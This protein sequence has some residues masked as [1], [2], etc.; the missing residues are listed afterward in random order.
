MLPNPAF[1]FLYFRHSRPSFRLG[2]FERRCLCLDCSR[3]TAFSLR[4]VRHV[5]LC[6]FVVLRPPACLCLLRQLTLSDRGLYQYIKY[7]PAFESGIRCLN[8][9][10]DQC[11]VRQ[12][13]PAPAACSAHSMLLAAR[14]RRLAHESPPPLGGLYAAVKFDS[15]RQQILSAGLQV[16]VA[17]YAA[18]NAECLQSPS[19]PANVPKS[20]RC[21]LAGVF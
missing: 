20:L 4:P 7:A 6:Q 16:P 19:G 1:C 2:P 3:L 15:P 11:P 12:M 9:R 21:L 5:T 18:P 10:R 13:G 8:N 14:W 17:T